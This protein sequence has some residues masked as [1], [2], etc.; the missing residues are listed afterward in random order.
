MGIFENRRIEYEELTLGSGTGS[1]RA[2]LLA[3]LHFPRC[4]ASSI[5]T[6]LEKRGVDI[7]FVAGDLFY[8]RA[9][10]DSCGAREFLEELSALMPVFFA[11]GNHEIR[12]REAEKIPAFLQECGVHDVTG[13]CVAFCIGG[14]EF[15]IAGDTEKQGAPRFAGK[16][17]KILLAHHPERAAGHALILRPDYI[18][19]GHAHGGQFR[20]FG[21][22]IYAPN[23]GLFPKYTSGLYPIAEG[24]DLIVS[25][26]IG[27]SR[28]PFRHL[29]I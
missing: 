14:A 2:A 28:F 26:G 23:Q 6:E 11:E 17:V 24:T 25:R 1:V 13:R 16:G 20:I 15:L 5:C 12:H 8:A 3:D 10:I 29:R 7:A 21:R 4:D 22:G 18:L 9:P 27:K 19:S